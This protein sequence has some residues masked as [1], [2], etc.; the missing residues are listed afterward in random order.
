MGE[1]GNSFGLYSLGLPKFVAIIPPRT[2]VGARTLLFQGLE[3]KDSTVC[4]AVP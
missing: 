4:V 1:R 2:P 3:L